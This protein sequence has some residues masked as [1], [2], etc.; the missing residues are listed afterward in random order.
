MKLRQRLQCMGVVHEQPGEGY[1]TWNFLRRWFISFQRHL[2]H[3]FWRHLRGFDGSDFEDDDEGDN[4]DDGDHDND[5]NDDNDEEDDDDYDDSDDDDS[6][7]YWAIF[8]PGESRDF[9]RD[10]CWGTCWGAG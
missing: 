1:P 8:V 7:W 2:R 9:C 10:Y 5:D 6:W 3:G 4:S